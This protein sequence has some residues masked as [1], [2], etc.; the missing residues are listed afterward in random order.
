MAQNQSQ[1][2]ASVAKAINANPYDN[3]VATIR[4]GGFAHTAAVPTQMASPSTFSGSSQT[5]TIE[6]LAGGGGDNTL[7]F[8]TSTELLGPLDGNTL[9]IDIPLGNPMSSPGQHIV[10]SGIVQHYSAQERDIN[11]QFPNPVEATGAIFGTDNA[12]DKTP[13]VTFTQGKGPSTTTF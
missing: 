2:G 8:A 3:T 4:A 7:D 11:G 13:E 12:T 6:V 5:I 1:L 10:N 9:G